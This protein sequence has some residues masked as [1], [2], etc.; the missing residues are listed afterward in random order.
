M[1]GR[2]P[3][4]LLAD[5][6]VAA[7]RLLLGRIVVAEHLERRVVRRVE[8]LAIAEDDLF[9]GA[10]QREERGRHH[11]EELRQ[12]EAMLHREVPALTCVMRIEADRAGCP[13]RFSDHYWATGGTAQYRT[14]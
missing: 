3:V 10:G 9:V 13:L 1:A 4:A 2:D 7:G 6:T 14:G 11:G 12:P 5:V 8:R